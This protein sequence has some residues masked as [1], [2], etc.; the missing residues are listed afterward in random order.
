VSDKDSVP[1]VLIERYVTFRD[2]AER[3]IHAT[4]QNVR[5][6]A[7]FHFSLDIGQVVPKSVSADLRV[8]GDRDDCYLEPVG[9]AQMYVVTKHLKETDPVKPAKLIVGAKFETRYF[10]GAYKLYDDGRRSGTL[11]LQVA[12]DGKVLGSYYS[13]KDGQKYE[14]AGKVSISPQYKIEFVVTYPRTAQHFTGYLFTGNGK[15]ITGTSRLEMRETG[16]YAVRIEK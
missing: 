12:D 2:G 1:I 6:F 7:G 8:V 4:G 10:N 15:A 13:D 16:F 5:L 3:T 9:K 11:R 14:V